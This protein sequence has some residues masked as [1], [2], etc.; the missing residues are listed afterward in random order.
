[1]IW[2]WSH[3]AVLAINALQGHS[4][5]C[6]IL[7]YDY[8]AVIVHQSVDFIFLLGLLLLA[9]IIYFDSH[10]IHAVVVS[11]IV[12]IYIACTTTRLAV[13]QG[14]YSIY[15]AILLEADHMLW[16]YTCIGTCHI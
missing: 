10:H 15:R 6:L 1:M 14:T 16:Q 3:E 8:L 7:L 2:L 4:F 9:S 13:Y 5:H 12:M 11:H